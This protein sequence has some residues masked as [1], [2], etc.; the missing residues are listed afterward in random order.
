VRIISVL[1]FRAEGIGQVYHDPYDFV[2]GSLYSSCR[3]E[4]G[5]GNEKGV[6][7]ARDGETVLTYEKID[8]GKVGS[9]EI[10]MHIFALSDEAYPIEIWEGI[11]KE[12]GS[13]LLADV[14]YQKPSIW[15]VYQPEKFRLS[16]K[17][18]GIKTLSFV[19]RQ[20]MHI[21][22]FSF[23][24]YEKA[25]MQLAAAEADVLYGDSFKRREDALRGCG[26]GAD[27]TTNCGTVSAGAIEEIGNNVSLVFED[28]DFGFEGASKL[29]ICG[30]AGLQNTIQVRFAGACGEVCQMLEFAPAKEY[31]EQTFDLE[32]V[33]GKNTV[34]FV[35][36]PGS[37]FDFGWFRFTANRL[38]E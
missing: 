7:T 5:N 6:S 32:K 8:F 14:I 11:P 27:G 4:A 30:R 38:S 20:K 22:G 21:K 26:E 2:Y 1:P 29:T 9:D 23:T 28:M 35:F 24:R 36:L 18:K 15:N 10:D 31:E 13:V 12:A 17:L 19:T 37:C 16:K 25:W 34:T 3:G 33:Q